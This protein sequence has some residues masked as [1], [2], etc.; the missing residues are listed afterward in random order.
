[1]NTVIITAGGFGKR[2][3][4]E[5]PK[6]FL[7]ING[8]A[9]L[10]Y[11]I[12]AFAKNNSE[13]QIL[14]TLPSDWHAYW[15][16]L[17]E[18]LQFT[19]PHQLIAGGIERYHSIQNALAHAT[20][21]L[22]AVHDGVRPLVCEATIQR[23]FEMAEKQGAAVPVI[24]AKESVRWTKNN[25]SKAVPRQEYVLVQTPQ[26]FHAHILRKAYSLPF[27]EGITD[28]ASLVEEAGYSI[29]LVEGNEENVKITHPMDLVLAEVLFGM[30]K[31]E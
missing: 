22:I 27:H 3:G 30:R 29:K 19:I 31:S 6:Q 8:K 26:V 13:N 4:S 9:I 7:E 21:K 25:I 2:M 18:Q 23:C 24:P 1:M 15:E 20:G 5:V 17:C 12:E 10:M 28:D 14:L 11:T 16:K